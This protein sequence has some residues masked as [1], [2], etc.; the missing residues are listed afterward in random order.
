M[1]FNSTEELI[2]ALANSEMVILLDDEKREN[3]GDIVMVAEKITPDAIN[4]MATYARGLICLAITE[5]KR[6]KLQLPL[7][8]PSAENTSTHGTRFT[9]SIEAKEE[10]STGISTADR[11]R[12]IKVAAAPNAQAEDLVRPGHIFPI[13]AHVGGVLE[14]AGHTEAAVDLSHLAGYEGAAVL[15]EIMNP[16][17]SMARAAEL[18]RFA[19]KYGLKIGTIA[20]LMSFRLEQ[21]N[22]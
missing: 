16:D 13:V 4:F 20:D 8:V 11:A 18:H 2:A 3:E 12:T 10:I 15:V 17:G 5:Q 22:P 6:R 7:M 1:T 14:R 9:V 19:R 21:E